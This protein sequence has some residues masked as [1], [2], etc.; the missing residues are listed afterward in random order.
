MKEIGGY[1]ELDEY[2]LDMLHEDGLHL[3]CGRNALAY[4]LEA[5]AI[6]TIWL[7]YFLCTSVR[8]TC[9]KYGVD[10][11]FYHINQDFLPGKFP[12]AEGE[13]V[14]LV[15]YYGQVPRQELIK[16][17]ETYKNV[18]VDFAQNYFAEPIPETDTLYTCRKYFGVCDG[19]IL[20]TDR[21]IDR[22]LEVDVSYER[23]HYI[24]GRYEKTASEFYQ[25][26]AFNNDAFAKES[27]KQM[28]KL[29]YNL[30]H[31]IEYDRV[32]KSRTENFEYL[33]KR[34][35]GVNQLRVCPV[36]GAFMYPLKIENAVE[37]RRKLLQHKIYIPVLWPNVLEEVPCEWTEWKLAGNMLPL[38]VDQRYTQKDMER[39]SELILED[40]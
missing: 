37:V 4:I 3:N 12:F 18:I 23:I 11:K 19:A 15:D 2:G 17:K 22:E 28:S 31:G 7:P 13:W 9:V 1:I 14:Y 6:K 5:R 32:R 10:T 40:W 29:T 8:E 30:L 21:K 24:L 16:L 34:L 25:E 36:D 26:S 33:R 39:V 38:P 35:E 27:I 20:Y